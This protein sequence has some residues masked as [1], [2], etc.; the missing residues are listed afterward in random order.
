MSDC[1]ES[2]KLTLA[3]AEAARLLRELADKLEAGTLKVGSESAA[4]RGELKVKVSG[5]SRDGV[6]S[7]GLKLQWKYSAVSEEASPDKGALPG[8]EAGPDSVDGGP[9]P[10]AGKIPSYKS[11]KKGMGST[12]KKIRARLRD[13]SIPEECLVEL[14]HRDA[15]L[16]LHYPKKGKAEDIEAFNDL[17]AAFVTAVQSGD[18]EA[19][20]QSVAALAAAEKSCHRRYK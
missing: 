6:A 2:R 19:V 5:K 20:G 16:M 17:S 9:S 15:E 10:T 1:E 18:L 14:F 12:F 11:I 7:L 13:G 3:P 4:P 8:E